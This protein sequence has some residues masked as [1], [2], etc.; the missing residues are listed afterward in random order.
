MSID[1]ENLLGARAL[2]KEAFVSVPH[3]SIKIGL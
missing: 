2:D 3:V 1:V